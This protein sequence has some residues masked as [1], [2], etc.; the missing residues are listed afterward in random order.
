MA[1]RHQS[2]RF[3][4]QRDQALHYFSRPGQGV[5]SRPI[6][7]PAAWRGDELRRRDDWS[8]RCTRR[9]L[10]EIESAFEHAAGT[11]KET[12][13]LSPGDF[14]LPGLGQM[15]A[16]VRDEVCS[17]RGFQLLRGLPV[18]SWSDAEAERFFWCFGLHLGIPGAQNPQGDLVGH[19]KDTGSTS[20]LA[21][22]R[23]Y[24]TSRE[25]AYH[26]D[27][28]DAVGLLCMHKAKTGGLSRIVS[29][30]TVF[31]ELMRRSPRHAARL[32]Q[33]YM[34]DTHGEGGI[35]AFPVT[36]CCYS[37]G[38]LRTSYHSDYFRSAGR[39]AGVEPL[40]GFDLDVLEHY[41][42]I[43]ND[44]ALFLEMDLEPGDVQ[45]ISNHGV[46]HAR[47]A[48]R[49]HPDPA[50]RR[51]LLRLWLSF[52]EPLSFADRLR[53]KRALLRLAWAVTRQPRTAVIA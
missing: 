11:G 26:C 49:D 23:Y 50:R 21:G 6:E 51:H 4:S 19:V 10:A 34:L 20:D 15:L 39:H 33:P 40:S 3:R 38:R 25:I 14:P 47:T 12:R 41:E 1:I 5:P 18:A 35:N 46:L 36:P 28:A 22:G 52:D 45:L 7:G 29:S 31:N 8:Y 27:A 53:K 42:T 32:F 30:V 16:A 9:D 17:G 2:S 13:E 44:P 37:S 24:R 48:Y 43:A